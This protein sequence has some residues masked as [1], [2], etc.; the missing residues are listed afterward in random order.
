MSSGTEFS[1]GFCPTTLSWP[2]RCTTR[3]VTNRDCF[4]FGSTS[5]STRPQL[6]AHG[7]TSA[8][9]RRVISLHYVE[10]ANGGE[11]W[12]CRWDRHPNP[13]NAR[14]HFH[15]PPAG[16]EVEDLALESYHPID[17]VSSVLAA[18]EQRI[19]EQWSD[20]DLGQ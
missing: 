7:W 13:H 2:R 4:E 16:E 5:I 20:D 17:V 18:I 8:G 1:N 14:V 3:T 6:K 11:R 10:T 9:F 15:R 19:A 12:E